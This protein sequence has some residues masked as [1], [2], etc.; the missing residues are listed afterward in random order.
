MTLAIVIVLQYVSSILR[1][2]RKTGLKIILFRFATKL[3]FVKSKLAAEGRKVS[4]E[5]S[6]KYLAQRKGAIKVLPAKPLTH[7]EIMKR[8]N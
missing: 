8:I 7:D 2:V 1:E 4:E 3:P 6:A 5:Y